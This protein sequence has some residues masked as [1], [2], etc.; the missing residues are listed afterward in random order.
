MNRNTKIAFAAV[1]VLVAV[2]G[3]RLLATKLPARLDGAEWHSIAKCAENQKYLYQ[4]IESEFKQT[5]KLPDNDFRIHG[6]PATVAWKCPA[7]GSGYKVH[8]EN[9]GNAHAA[10]IEDEQDSHPT[11]V[12]WWLRGAHPVVQTMGD[13][14]IHLFKNGKIV[15]MAGTKTESKRRT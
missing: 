2:A 7:C 11:T 8:L 5:G 12:M 14:T 6:V 4:S 3:L 9:Y 13:G 10:L 15:T 1:S